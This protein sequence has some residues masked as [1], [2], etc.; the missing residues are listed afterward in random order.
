[1]RSSKYSVPFCSLEFVSSVDVFLLL[2]PFKIKI[3]TQTHWIHYDNS[4]EK[5][6]MDAKIEKKL[7]E[8]FKQ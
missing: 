7:I 1:M 4:E 3:S 8:Q 6:I 5:H 2:F